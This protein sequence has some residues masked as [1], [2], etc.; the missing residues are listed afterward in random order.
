VRVLA[1]EVEHLGDVALDEPG[2]C[3]AC[4]AVPREAIVLDA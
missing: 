1:G 3:L 2:T 4:Q